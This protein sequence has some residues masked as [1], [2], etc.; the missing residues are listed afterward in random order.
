MCVSMS[1]IPAQRVDSVCFDV[2]DSCTE[3]RLCVSM[4]LIPAQRVDCVFLCI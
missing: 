4:Y 3:S 2:F 1:L